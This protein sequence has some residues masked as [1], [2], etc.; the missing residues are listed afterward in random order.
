[1]L[2]YKD[3]LL[4][5]INDKRIT[6]DSLARRISEIFENIYSLSGLVK[7]RDIFTD[8]QVCPGVTIV[9]PD[10]EYAL[11]AVAKRIDNR[12]GD[13]IDKETVV[14]AVSTQVKVKVGTNNLLLCGDSSYEAIKDKLEEYSLIQL[15]HHG[16]KEQADSIFEQKGSLGITYYV[17]DNTGNTNGGSK[18]LP[19]RGYVIKNTKTGDQICTGWNSS[20]TNIPV[21]SYFRGL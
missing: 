19:K 9:G 14:N 4:K 15:P 2:K 13:T 3:E 20:L 10:Q 18:D 5:R 21:R 6:R 8:T 12:Q 1:M 11:D 17:S 7:L 16:K